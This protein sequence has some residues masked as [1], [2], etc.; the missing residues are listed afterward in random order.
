MYF[1]VESGHFVLDPSF[2]NED[3]SY[4]THDGVIKVLV[5]NKR[6]ISKFTKEC[7]ADCTFEYDRKIGPFNQYT[8]ELQGPIIKY[9]GVL[10]EDPPF[11]ECVLFSLTVTPSEISNK[12]HRPKLLADW[13][14]GL[15]HPTQFNR[16]LKLNFVVEPC[17]DNTVKV[18][19]KVNVH[20]GADAS[21]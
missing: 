18:M 21:L 16:L 4:E 7:F 8:I 20:S 3:G 9:N 15:E 13:V 11:S 19:R 1:Q 2:E 6:D 17:D 5:T 12:N 10:C 14:L